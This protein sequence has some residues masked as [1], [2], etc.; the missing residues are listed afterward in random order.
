MG[1]DDEGPVPSPGGGS[2]G[3]KGTPDQGTRPT[4]SPTPPRTRW[5]GAAP[6]AF[7]AFRRVLLLLGEGRDEGGSTC[8]QSAIRIPHLKG[9]AFCLLASSGQNRSATRKGPGDR[10]WRSDFRR[11]R[12]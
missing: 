12:L 10:R 7:G 3:Q 4:V 2:G 1:G 5:P 8:A 9:S 11:Q 6:K